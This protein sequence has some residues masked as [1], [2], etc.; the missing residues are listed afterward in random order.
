M[1]GSW[2]IN[3]AIT[4]VV[5]TTLRTTTLRCS[6][7]ATVIVTAL[8]TQSKLRELSDEVVYRK[9]SH[10]SQTQVYQC[11]AYIEKSYRKK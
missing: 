4:A 9:E 1:G 5:K 8:C 7:S 6:L 10:P 2:A 11:F 3:Q